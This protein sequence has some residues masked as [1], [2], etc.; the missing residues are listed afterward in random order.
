MKHPVFSESG[1]DYADEHINEV[2]PRKECQHKWPEGEDL[3]E[4]DSACLLCG[5]SFLQ[6][7]FMECE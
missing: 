6:Y 5:R 7:V 4:N 2:R 3:Y 1:F